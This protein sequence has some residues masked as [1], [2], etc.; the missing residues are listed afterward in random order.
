MTQSYF[1]NIDLYLEIE[2]MKAKHSIRA[3]VAWCTCPR[4]IR[5]LAAKQSEG[6]QVELIVNDDA[7]NRKADF[8]SIDSAGGIVTFS[9]KSNDIMHHK[10]CIIDNITVIAGS[11]NWT[12][13][14]QTNDEQ[15]TVT[16]DDPDEVN[17][18]SEQFDMLS[19][20]AHN[21]SKKTLKQPKYPTPFLTEAPGAP[22]HCQ[23]L[24]DAAT[25]A[26]MSLLKTL[27]IVSPTMSLGA[28]ATEAV[29]E[30]VDKKI[31]EWAKKQK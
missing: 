2:L 24:V 19:I 5:I 27:G 4:I 23:A 15:L 21:K 14:A 11:Y 12:R 17:R 22:K 30:W 28:M 9:N 16:V 6:V 31:K 25:Y 18:Y 8:S 10:F 7:T 1:E 13:H 3:A 26:N 29:S 20:V